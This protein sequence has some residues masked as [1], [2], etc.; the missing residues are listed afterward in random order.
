MVHLSIL[1][2]EKAMRGG[3]GGLFPTRASGHEPL[4]SAGV[5]G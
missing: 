4:R 2:S 5:V 3:G 1:Q